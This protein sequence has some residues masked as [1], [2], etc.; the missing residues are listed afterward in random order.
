[1][2]PC[3]EVC[4]PVSC[5]SVANARRTQGVGS[6]AGC[7]DQEGSGTDVM[8][9]YPIVLKDDEGALL[10]TSPDFPELTTFGE[11]RQV[12][13]AR[14]VDAL[15][16][17]IAA[18]MYSRLSI[19]TPTTG[20]VY[21]TLPTLTTVKLMLYPGMRD[22]GVGKAEL[23]RRLVGICRKVA[24]RDNHKCKATY[25]TLEQDAALERLA[26]ARCDARES[27]PSAGMAVAR[28]RRSSPPRSRERGDFRSSSLRRRCRTGGG[29]VR[30]GRRCPRFAVRP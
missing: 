20:E 19:P 13:I 27:A 25:S 2:S 10:V 14:A 8:L 30:P 5:Q 28:N 16:E 21:A 22:R 4:A 1:M 26:A 9:S 12:A 6:G 29:S 7:N 17:A 24:P 3:G 11:D 23:A 18:R 15:E